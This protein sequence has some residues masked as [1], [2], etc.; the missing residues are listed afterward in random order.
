MVKFCPTL[1]FEIFKKIKKIENSPKIVPLAG[2]PEKPAGPSP[3]P[4]DP[5]PRGANFGRFVARGQKIP[6][7]RTPQGQI[8]PGDPKSGVFGPRPGKW[9]KMG[10][11][12]GKSQYEVG[13]GFPRGP[14][15]FWPILVQIPFTSQT[16]PKSK[17]DPISAENPLSGPKTGFSRGPQGNWPI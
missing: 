12:R 13:A 16:V 1:F 6:K 4:R 10:Q 9:L 11:N 5:G 14:Q 8:W 15:G 17:V 3:L 7:N 2:P